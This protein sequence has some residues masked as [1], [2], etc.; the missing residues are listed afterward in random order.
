MRK[1]LKLKSDKSLDNRRVIPVA[2]TKID[3]KE[4]F[5]AMTLV[6]YL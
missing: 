6:E 5:K 2:C 1:R 3:K 4:G